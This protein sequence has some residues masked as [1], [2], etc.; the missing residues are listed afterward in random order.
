[1]KQF[2]HQEHEY[3]DAH[4]SSVNRLQYCGKEVLLVGSSEPVLVVAGFID[5]EFA[6]QKEG[7][8]TAVTDIEPITDDA[9]RAELSD[10]LSKK[11]TNKKVIFWNN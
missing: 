9:Q 10:L 8:K 1:M 7:T 2:Y 11:V 4:S 3:A 6:K 5:G